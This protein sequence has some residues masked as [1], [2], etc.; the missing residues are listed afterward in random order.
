[1][2]IFLTGGSGFVGRHLLRRLRA[3]GHELLALVRSPTAAEAVLREGAHPWRCGLDDLRGVERALDQCG[4]VVHAA[5]HLKFWGP[6]SQFEAANVGLTRALVGAARSA[7]VPNFVHIGAASVVMR[8][9]GPLLEVDES[10]PLVDARWLPYSTT[11]AR[12]ESAVLRAAT[13]GFRTVSLR[14]PFIWG[15]GD[16]VDRDLGAAIRHGRFGWFNGGRFPYATCHVANLAEAVVLALRGD[17]SGEALFV[18]DGDP[19]DLRS[20]LGRRVAAAGLPVTQAS[21]P[22]AAAWAMAGA[23]EFAWRALR[24]ETEPPLVRETVR[25]MGYPF[26]VDIS[27][28]RRRLGYAPIISIEQGL[29][30]LAATKLESWVVDLAGRSA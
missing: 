11:K 26:T 29:D 20:F 24:L 22:T 30:Q 10:A 4:A 25:L 23:L 28:A 19:V 17:L 3:Q 7:G 2:K 13:S 27:R 6:W 5:A 8:T 14:P 9:R 21:V 15:P 18:S 1:M 16:A 12:A